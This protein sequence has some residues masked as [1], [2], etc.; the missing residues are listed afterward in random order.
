L[1][2]F[3]G[4]VGNPV[5]LGEF[6]KAAVALVLCSGFC[7]AQEKDVLIAKVRDE[8]WGAFSKKDIATLRSV[9]ADDYYEPTGTGVVT[10]A[11]V[12]G[13]APKIN[14]RDF[15][16]DKF[17]V[18]HLSKNAAIVSYEVQQHWTMDGQ[19][20]PAHVRASTAWVNRSGK[21]LIVFHQETTAK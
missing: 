8:F 3:Y 21:W 19:E 7:L 14:M 16:L 13:A 18:I 10:K 1:F 20:G 17:K 15:A 2:H 4:I 6:M 5:R 12:L 11:D 9:L